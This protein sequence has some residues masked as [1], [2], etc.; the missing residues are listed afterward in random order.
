MAERLGRALTWDKRGGGRGSRGCGNS[1]ARTLGVPLECGD[2]GPV[3]KRE[4]RVLGLAPERKREPWSVWVAWHV[5]G[6]EAGAHCSELVFKPRGCGERAEGL[7]RLFPCS[8]SFPAGDFCSESE[9]QL[10]RLP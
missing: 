8:S 7:A 3:L 1:Q 5:D 4:V 9:I 2:V 10:S 6:T